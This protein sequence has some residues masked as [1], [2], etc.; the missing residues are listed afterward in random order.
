MLKLPM[1]LMD[2]EANKIVTN[3]VN[4]RLLALMRSLILDEIISDMDAMMAIIDKEPSNVIRIPLKDKSGKHI[5]VK[6]E[7]HITPCDLEE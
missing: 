5:N 1:Q 6:T 2:A 4:E 3:F 7:Y